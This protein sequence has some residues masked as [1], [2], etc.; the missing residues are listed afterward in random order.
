MRITTAFQVIGLGTVTGSGDIALFASA[1]A[2]VRIT[3][4]GD[5]DVFGGGDVSQSIT[6]SGDVDK[7]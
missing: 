7:K 3:G 1:D 6:G 5:V 4:S 2:D